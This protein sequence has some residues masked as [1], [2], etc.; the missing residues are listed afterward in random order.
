MVFNLKKE[1][2]NKI[3]SGIKTHEYRLCNDFWNKRINNLIY[4]IEND[5]EYSDFYPAR[6]IKFCMGYPKT[7][8]YSKSIIARVIN[9]TKHNGLNTDLHINKNVWDIE[10]E[11]Y[12]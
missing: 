4:R 6:N 11:L 8:D 12:K 1:W 7:D 5:S 9:I 10:F 3:K 2:F